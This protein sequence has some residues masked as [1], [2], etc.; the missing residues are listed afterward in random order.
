MAIL[1]AFL[2]LVAQVQTTLAAITNDAIATATYS[3]NPVNSTI[4]SESVPVA[5]AAPA[6]T[7]TKTG[8]LNDDDGTPGLSAGDTISYTVTVENTG[9]V[10]LTS[11][12]ASDPLV[13]LTL[14]SGDTDGD[15]EIDPG[16]TWNYTA[17]YIIT[18]G[19]LSSNGGGDGDIDNTVTISTDQL[20]DDF[21]SEAVPIIPSSSMNVTK[22][23]ILNDDDGTPGLSAGDTISYVITVENTGVLSLTNVNLADVLD[24]NGSSIALGTTGPTGDTDSDNEID[25]TETWQYLASHTI[26]QANLDDGNDLVNTATVTTDQV[27]PTFDTDT[28]VLA[29]LNTSYTMTKSSSLA[30]GD[31]DGLGDVGEII[32]YT[33]TFTNTGNQTLTNLA[34]SDPLP[35]LST[36]ACLGDGDSDGDIDSLLPGASSTC[37]ATYTIVQADVDNGSLTNTATTTATGPDG[38]T[39]V[40][41]DDTANDNS[42]IILMDRVVDLRV[43]KTATAPVAV[44]P[45]VL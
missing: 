3:G 37:S 31:G 11:V 15:S 40:I 9:N 27:G 26:T 22:T 33:F 21:A 1:V 34:A 18:A 20:P 10:S 43:T 29:G 32:T 23:G 2:F 7:V 24:Q 6:M 41:E 16:E 14:A 45:N 12:V 42:T 38:A 28:Q 35:G 44:L 30:D 5:A 39:P 8:V 36:I 13:T 17:S 19:D 25:P 4:S